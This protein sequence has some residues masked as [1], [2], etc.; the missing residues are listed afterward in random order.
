MT[1]YQRRGRVQRGQSPLGVGSL[2]GGSGMRG[3]FRY[4]AALCAIVFP[5]AVLW[6][7][8]AQSYRC[9]D[10]GLVGAAAAGSVVTG[11]VCGFN[12]TCPSDVAGCTL[13]GLAT[14]NGIG[15]VGVA[16]RA[17]PGFSASCTGVSGCGIGVGSI[18]DLQPGEQ[19]RITCFFDSD[20]LAVAARIVIT[21]RADLLST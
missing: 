16:V 1:T 7:A 3:D 18:A 9:M 11:P 19:T 10:T 14:V 12:V 15:I 5:L 20:S 8:A 21:C 4:R 13:N 17:V 2:E 6:P